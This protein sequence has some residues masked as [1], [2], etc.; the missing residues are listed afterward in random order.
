VSSDVLRFV[1]LPTASELVPLARVVG[2]QTAS[3]A[4]SLRGD[5]EPLAGTDASSQQG[6]DGGGTDDWAPVEQQQAAQARVVPTQ[7]LE[8]FASAHDWGFGADTVGG[9]VG[10]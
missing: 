1:T 8:R 9:W 6:A 10:G 4:S 7:S 3:N 2:S 5:A